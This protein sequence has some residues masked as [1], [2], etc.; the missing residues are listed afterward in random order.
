MS[1]GI[2]DTG[3]PPTHPP[4]PHHPPRGGEGPRRQE[5]ESAEPRRHGEHRADARRAREPDESIAPE[6]P[7][8]EAAALQ[9]FVHGLL[10]FL[11]HDA[12]A[13][14]EARV[15]RVMA[16]IA[17]EDRVMPP[18]VVLRTI[19][20]RRPAGLVA[21]ALV[22]VGVLAFLLPTE[23]SATATVQS[24]LR[25]L[26]SGGERRYDVRVMLPGRNNVEEEAMATVDARGEG[27]LVVRART[28]RGDRVILGRDEQG[29]WIIR[30]DGSVDR[31]PPRQAWPRW[32]DAGENTVL[33]ESVDAQLE[34]VLKQYNLERTEPAPLP[35]RAGGSGGEG[36]T[37]YER[38]TARR[39][40]PSPEPERIELW[41]ERDTRLVK[42][43]ELHWAERPWEGPPGPGGAAGPGRP[44]VGMPG[45]PGAGMPPEQPLPGMGMPHGPMP[46]GMRRPGPGPGPRL[47]PGPEDGGPG[48]PMPG[49]P[50][51]HPPPRPRFLDGPPEFGPGRHPP[52]PRMIVFERVEAPAFEA[53]W[54]SP[55]AH[56]R[57]SP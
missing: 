51:P 12:A 23:Q 14:Q 48:A 56:T 33:L 3:L 24:S 2:E 30:P 27:Y 21:A 35:G 50:P 6:A 17:A 5:E 37:K 54:F 53:G 49:P 20:W 8:G 28:P 9:Q 44:E 26:R 16:A 46:R 32:L 11:H 13:R 55:E 34:A 52:P 57:E 38:I 1:G 43:M 36:A 15:R 41:L 42:R 31:F 10:A 47:G 18:P 22:I 29:R 25:A 39:K 40:S 4:H 45:P 7:G 19:G